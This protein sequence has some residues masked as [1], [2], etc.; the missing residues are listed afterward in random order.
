MLRAEAGNQDMWRWWHDKIII[1][2][3]VGGEEDV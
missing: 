3:D 2:S 1:L